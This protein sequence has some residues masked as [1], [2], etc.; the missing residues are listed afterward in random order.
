MLSPHLFLL[1]TCVD[2]RPKAGLA[3][4]LDD[5]QSQTSAL[6][7][8]SPAL[9]EVTSGHPANLARPALSNE[10]AAFGTL[11]NPPVCPYRIPHET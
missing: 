1:K 9:P 8:S 4:S 11:R 6:L 7:P 3:L 2:H 5:C 10:R